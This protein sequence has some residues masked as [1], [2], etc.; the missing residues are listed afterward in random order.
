MEEGGESEAAGQ[1]RERRTG[2]FWMEED[3]GGGSK[4]D[5]GLDL[6]HLLLFT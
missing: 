1:A 6:I 3:C 5:T 4:A 2:G